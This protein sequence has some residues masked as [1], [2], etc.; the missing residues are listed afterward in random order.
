MSAAMVPNAAA[1]AEKESTH[2]TKDF[3][4]VSAFPE[5]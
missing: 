3:E 2:C 1:D 4:G 5:R